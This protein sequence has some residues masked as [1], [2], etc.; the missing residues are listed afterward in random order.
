MSGTEIDDGE[1]RLIAAEYVLGTLD[2]AEAATAAERVQSEA[3]FADEVRFWERRLY[4][5]TEL[6]PPVPAPEGLLPRI[7]ATIGGVRAPG[8]VAGSVQTARPAND[9][10]LRFW[11]A[12]AITGFAVAASLAAVLVLRPA[13][14]PLVAVLSPTGSTLAVLV[15]VTEPD[16]KVAVRPSGVLQIAAGRDLQMWSLPEGASKPVSL[17]LL[18]VGGTMVPGVAAG[19]KLLVSLEPTGGSPT[20]LPTGPVVYGGVLQA[21]K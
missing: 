21:T 1:P 7:E 20:G 9:N 2:T 11:R 8:N 18:P 16:G 19:T 13:P 3:G 4:P 12:A 17:G 5:L 14:V 15:A 10:A 6:V